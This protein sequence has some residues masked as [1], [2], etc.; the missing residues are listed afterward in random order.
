[1]E[2]RN[3]SR[4]TGLEVRDQVPRIP[5]RS[6]G[7]GIYR[8]ESQWPVRHIVANA[9]QRG[10]IADQDCIYS[11]PCIEDPNT[12]ITLWESGAVG[13]MPIQ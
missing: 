4:R 6:Q 1:M 12:G 13:V 7:Q 8:K 5:S 11:V 3:H 2:S 9:D 10:D